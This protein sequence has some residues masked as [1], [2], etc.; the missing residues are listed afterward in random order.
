MRQ[1]E[2]LSSMWCGHLIYDYDHACGRLFFDVR[3][4]KKSYELR[5]QE[6][7]RRHSYMMLNYVAIHLILCQ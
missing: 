6:G 5:R 7:E 4:A 1:I 3:E 2:A